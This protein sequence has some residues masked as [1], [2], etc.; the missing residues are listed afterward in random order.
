M[1]NL[2]ANGGVIMNFTFGMI[3][4]GAF[5]VYF[6]ELSKHVLG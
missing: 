6:K 2:M 5:N 1:L 3:S 4:D